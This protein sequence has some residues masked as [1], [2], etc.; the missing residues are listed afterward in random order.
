MPANYEEY[1]ASV[2]VPVYNGGAHIA[3]CIES[4]L[5]QDFPRK[6]YEVIIVNNRSTD[7]TAEIVKRYPVAALFEG[8]RG[9][10]AARNTGIRASSSHFV[11]FTDADCIPQPDWLSQIVLA[12]EQG[13][14]GAGGSIVSYYGEDRI[15]RYIDEIVFRQRYNITQKNPPHITTANAC[16]VRSVLFKIGLFDESFPYAAGEDRDLGERLSLAGSHFVFVPTA[17]VRHKH[18]Q[19]LEGFYNQRFRH[20]AGQFY[21]DLKMSNRLSM[22][23]MLSR[24]DTSKP[25]SLTKKLLY[26]GI[27]NEER[28]RA[29]LNLIDTGAYI[30]GLLWTY[31]HFF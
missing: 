4:L 24:L 5:N 25:I 6:Q 22:W 30:T 2:V 8:K 28:F 13:A 27:S 21:S 20:A 10:A 1:I 31:L 7:D 19:T 14:T 16:Y 29:F 9:P 11:A 15:S 17:I 26:P 23:D 12:M 3:D 18:P